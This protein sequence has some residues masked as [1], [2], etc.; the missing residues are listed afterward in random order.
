M[1][2]GEAANF[3]AYSFA[4]AVIVT[5]MG[6]FSV[7]ISAILA[8]IMLGEKLTAKGKLGCGLLLAGSTV[9]VMHAPKEREVSSVIEIVN[10]IVSPG[11][12]ISRFLK[13]WMFFLFF[14]L[15]HQCS[16]RM[17]HLRQIHMCAYVV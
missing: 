6:G 12:S 17:A 3:A 13:L 8:D 7:V 16:Y 15:K 5:P 10:S 2:V 11:H 14:L 9:I 1:I 4:P